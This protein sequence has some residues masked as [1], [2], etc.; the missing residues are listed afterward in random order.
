MKRGGGIRRRFLERGKR[1]STQNC[2]HDWHPNRGAVAE[3]KRT[4]PTGIER[5][6]GKAKGG[7]QLPTSAVQM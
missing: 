7:I 4:P 3:I 1:T 2:K 5:Y 6:A